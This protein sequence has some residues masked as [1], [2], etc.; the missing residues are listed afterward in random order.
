MLTI[1]NFRNI[2]GKEFQLSNGTKY[3]IGIVRQ[4]HDHYSFG[5]FELDDRNIANISGAIVFQ[6]HKELRDYG[7]YKAYPLSNQTM[8]GI[9]KVTPEN[10]T[11]KN[12]VL[13]LHIQT[14][15]II[16]KR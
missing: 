13:E 1:E 6:L 14:G 4:Y 5:V 8:K 9:A 7:S 10:L 2:E 15:M 12:F 16:N 3:I 11:L